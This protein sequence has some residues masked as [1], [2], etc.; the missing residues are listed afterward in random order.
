MAEERAGSRHDTAS[1]GQSKESIPQSTPPPKIGVEYFK[2]NR[3]KTASI[4]SDNTE[5]VNEQLEWGE[6]GQS[7]DQ[8]VWGRVYAATNAHNK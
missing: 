1:Q 7:P 4:V 8:Q 3:D 5:I 2:Y 6:Q